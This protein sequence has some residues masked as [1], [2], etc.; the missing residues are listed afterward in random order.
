MIDRILFK[1][2]RTFDRFAIR[3]LRVITALAEKVSFSEAE[4]LENPVNQVFVD[5][6]TDNAGKGLIGAH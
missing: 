5:F 6:L 1:T 4:L 2:F 3:L